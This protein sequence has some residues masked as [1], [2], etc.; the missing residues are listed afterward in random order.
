MLSPCLGTPGVNDWTNERD[1]DTPSLLIP[2]DLWRPGTDHRTLEMTLT[3]VSLLRSTL[4]FPKQRV[5][6]N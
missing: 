6:E 3:G 2:V 1:A 4:E 5:E